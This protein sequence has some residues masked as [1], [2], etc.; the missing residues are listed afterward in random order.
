MKINESQI[1]FGQNIV[2]KDE[3]IRTAGQVLL[4]NGFV[5][6]E[7]INSMIKKEETDITYIGNGVA[8][9]HGRYEDRQYIQKSGISV[10]HYP[11]GIDYNNELAYLVIGIAANDDDHIEILQELAIK[12]SDESYVI[13]LI[14]SD[15]R[16]LFIEKFNN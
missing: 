6:K 4:E 2:S 5:S 9:P 3:A 13:S 7:Y 12:L 8:I 1:K 11:E 10:I 14:T 16:E 15:T